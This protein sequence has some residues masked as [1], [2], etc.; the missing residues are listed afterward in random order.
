M[1]LIM[2]SLDKTLVSFKKDIEKGFKE[3]F[4]T[5]SEACSNYNNDFTLSFENF[6]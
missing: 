3:I 2:P 6:N 1:N 5:Y 4:M